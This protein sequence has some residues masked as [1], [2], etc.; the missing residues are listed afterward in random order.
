M[1]YHHLAFLCAYDDFRSN[2]ACALS[3][4]VITT[5]D[6]FEAILHHLFDDLSGLW[7]Q[8]LQKTSDRASS[9]QILLFEINE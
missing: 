1:V 4:M 6:A 3:G 9:I 5:V 7:T 8:S 2:L